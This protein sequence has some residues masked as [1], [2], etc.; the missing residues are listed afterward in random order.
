[1][2]WPQVY[3]LFPGNARE[4][5][6]FYQ[7]CFGGDLELFTYQQFQRLD[8]P[9]DAIAHGQ[10]RGPVEIL[11]ADAGPDEDAVA[12]NGLMLSVLGDD[13]AKLR[14]WFDTL[15]AT[16]RVVDP[17]QKR[18]WGDCDGQVIDQFGLRWL[19]GFGAKSD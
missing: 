15:A 4:A 6:E 7:S 11:A 14:A 9:P 2:S 3:V 8:G 10:L 5:L 12:L 1:M 19:I 16:G 13:E 18:P 17:L